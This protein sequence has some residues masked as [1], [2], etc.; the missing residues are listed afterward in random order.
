MTWLGCMEDSNPWPP[1]STTLTIKNAGPLSQGRY[2][3]VPSAKR[4]SSSKRRV[5][6]FSIKHGHQNTFFCFILFY[7][8][9][10][11]L[12][13]FILFFYSTLFYSTLSLFCFLGPCVQHMEIPRLGVESELQLPT[14]TIAIAMQDPSHVCDL[15]HG[16]WQHQTLN[17]LS[18]VRHQT[19]ILMDTSWVHYH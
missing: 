18:K 1:S 13:Y 11:I 4:M 14:Y 12:F 8:I 17:P 10:F 16:L 3:N 2:G 15:H 19:C 6:I 5:S 7:F 9:L